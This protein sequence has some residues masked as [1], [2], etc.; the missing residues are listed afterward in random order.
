MYKKT[1]KEELAQTQ[2]GECKYAWMPR[3]GETM[4][5]SCQVVMS[6]F[7]TEGMVQAKSNSRDLEC[8]WWETC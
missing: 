6:R 3:K 4:K 5:G 1:R 7:G 2:L 8:Q